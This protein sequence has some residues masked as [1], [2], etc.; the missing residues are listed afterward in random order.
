[1]L[2]WVRVR[3]IINLDTNSYELSCIFFAVGIY[4][5]FY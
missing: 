1:M 3:F 2:K 4:L 5:T